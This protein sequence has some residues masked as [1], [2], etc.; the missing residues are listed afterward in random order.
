MTVGAASAPRPIE[1]VTVVGTGLMGT[2]VALAA[3]RAGASVIGWDVDPPTT[4]RAAAVGGFTG[5]ATLEEAVEGAELVVVCTPIPM[6]A[7]AVAAA[8][9]T[10]SEAIV[11]EVGSIMDSVAKEV[12][13]RADP[14][15]LRR[16][17][18]GHPMGG[19]ER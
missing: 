7:D 10:T 5:A 12:A 1:R 6:I 16:F 15:H 19:S 13:E 8:L 11:T 9:S 17:V 4:A 18:P 2:S 3:A 14:A